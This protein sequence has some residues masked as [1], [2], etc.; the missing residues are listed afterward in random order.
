MVPVT[1]YTLWAALDEDVSGSWMIASCD[2]WSWEGDP[3]KWEAEFKAARDRNS[4]CQFRE[5]SLHVDH[6][7][8]TQAFLPPEIVVGVSTTAPEAQ[9][10]KG[11]NG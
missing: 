9:P 3:D 6:D 5:I 8:V 10:K 4:G 7:L 2:E 1:I 11:Q